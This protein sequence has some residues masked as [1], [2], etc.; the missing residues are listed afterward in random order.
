MRESVTSD[1]LRAFMREIA[2]EAR[3]AGRIYITGGASAVLYGW[4][5]TTLD[6]DIKV[7]PES[8]RVLRSLPEIKERMNINIELASPGDF[9]PPLPQWE[10]RSPFI[11]RIG[12]LAFHHFDFYT[13]CLSKLERAHRKDFNDVAAMV[14]SGLVKPKKL[15]ELFRAVEPELFRY[16]AIDPPTLRA[17]VE[18]FALQ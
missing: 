1:R 8:D 3:E 16:P 15:L 7:V 4:R 18:A 5:E 10:D 2:K 9:V 17:A 6:I 11:D 12:L 13:Q 14:S